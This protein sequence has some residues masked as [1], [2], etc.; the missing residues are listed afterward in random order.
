MSQKE[1]RCSTWASLW[2]VSTVAWTGAQA[3]TLR[4]RLEAC[5]ANRD[6]TARLHCFD[7]LA[8]SVPAEK[9]A[10][11]APASA[12]DTQGLRTP[13]PPKVTQTAHIVS[14]SQ[15]DGRKYRIVLDNDQVWQESEHTRDL[16]LAAGQTVQIKPGVLGSFFLMLDSGLSTRIRRIR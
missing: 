6:D 16:D 3:D 8:K 7:E 5:A 1:H 10:E 9:P 14:V 11:K 2:L 12:M 13:A 4:E 15:P